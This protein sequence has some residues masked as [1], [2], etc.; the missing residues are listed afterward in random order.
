MRLTALAAALSLAAL[1]IP[2]G[3]AG[4]AAQ[5][6]KTS[7]QGGVG[8]QPA[9]V[10]EIVAAA[11]DCF[12]FV[13]HHGQIDSEGLKA[14]GWQFAGKEDVKGSAEMPANATVYLGKGN[15]IMILRHTGLSATCQTVSK[16]DDIA[17]AE[18]VRTGIGTALGAKP[19][20]DY[21]GDDQF[22]AMILSR[23]GPTALDT[24]LI[25]DAAR[26][27]VIGSSKDGTHV[28]S[29]IMVPRILD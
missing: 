29:T 16:V 23:L 14:A 17:R 22:K 13:K 3:M 28:V 27:T 20:K 18:E 5:A 1:A 24:M 25:S 26:F 15:V 12:K 11:G 19:A 2:S 6:V 8:S 10:A 21:K 7:E 4:V 9:S